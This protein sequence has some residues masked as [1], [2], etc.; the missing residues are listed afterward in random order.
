[1]MMMI[2]AC[3][4]N[5]LW[6]YN[7]ESSFLYK[8]QKKNI[9]INDMI[10]CWWWS[11]QISKYDTN[12]GIETFVQSLNRS[13]RAAQLWSFQTLKENGTLFKLHGAL[14]TSLY[15]DNEY[16]VVFSDECLICCCCCCCRLSILDNQGNI[17][18]QM[19]RWPAATLTE[20]KQLPKY[21]YTIPVLDTGCMQRQL[22]TWLTIFMHEKRRF[23]R[24]GLPKAKL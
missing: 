12:E 1:M 5:I 22:N 7:G 21:M 9:C 3:Y 23:E 15:M 18:L 19:L 2:L 10:I 4:Q 11:K 14:S 6:T 20:P 16:K 13:W 8:I 24:R 17:A